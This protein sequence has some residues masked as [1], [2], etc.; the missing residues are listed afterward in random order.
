M[1]S[2]K[3]GSFI[4]QRQKEYAAVLIFPDI[5][6]V[7][8]YPDNFQNKLSEHNYTVHALHWVI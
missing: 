4:I 7:L 2:T 1:G 3:V 5:L 6:R 8:L